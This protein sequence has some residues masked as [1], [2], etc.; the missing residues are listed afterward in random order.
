MNTNLAVLVT[1][2]RKHYHVQ[3]N[4]YFDLQISGVRLMED[5]TDMDPEQRNVLHILQL[6]SLG[7]LTQMLRQAPVLC[8]TPT[9][10]LSVDNPISTGFGPVIVV[11]AD[12][13]DQVL[14][15]LSG[16]LY[17]CGQMTSPL[18]DMSKELLCCRTLEQ[19][20]DVGY[21]WLKNPMIVADRH[22]VV[23]EGTK[24]NQ[25]PFLK[26]EDMWLQDRFFPDRVHINAALDAMERSMVSAWP[27]GVEASERVPQ[28]LC[29]TLCAEEKVDG[30]LFL[31]MVEREPIENSEAMLE[32]LGNFCTLL[33]REQR[34]GQS[35]RPKEQDP[36]GSVLQMMLSD[37]EVTRNQM[38]RH[39][40]RLQLHLKPYRYILCVQ[41]TDGTPLNLHPVHGL[42][43]ILSAAVPH[44]LSTYYRNTLTMLIESDTE[45][46]DVSAAWASLAELLKKYGFRAGVSTV[47]RDVM[48]LQEYFYQGLQAA[49]LGAMFCPEKTLIPY[50][51]VAPYHMLE[52]V[53]S[54]T[55]LLHFC[56]PGILRLQS[57]DKKN[58]SDLMRTLQVY[59]EN[60]RNKAQTAQ[61]LFLH[62]NT[63]KYRINQISEVVNLS[64]SSV[65]DS[66][67][68]YLSIMI[69]RYIQQLPESGEKNPGAVSPMRL[70]GLL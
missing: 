13:V 9:D 27:C 14:V 69:L 62:L 42:T 25:L 50:Y 41:P 45:I 47:C 61:A 39:I 54:F 4:G 33:L 17:R 49:R 6:R 32:L 40:E 52:Y 11:F 63:V 16:I 3:C 44:T 70:N 5:L 48:D 1:E 10:N 24:T 43:E 46:Q 19:A 7:Q 21:R 30:F 34:S 26:H 36:L 57:M 18:E 60:G 20:L 64:S 58:N 22:H 66:T 51:E 15:T 8:V 28:Y 53:S 2:L 65:E 59:L 38:E 35:T 67:R 31:F 37:T 68:L 29:K 55:S 56:D 23:L 12:R